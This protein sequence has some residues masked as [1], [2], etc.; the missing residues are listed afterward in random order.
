MN[1]ARVV[2]HV[3][4][5]DFL[6]RVR[7]YSFLVVL[8]ATVFACYQVHTGMIGIIVSGCRGTLNS[9]WIG[10]VMTLTATTLLGLVG[11]YIVNNSIALDEKSRVGQLLAATPVSKLQYISGKAL[12]NFCVLAVIVFVLMLSAPPLQLLAGEDKHVRLWVLIGPFI[13]VSLPVL[14]LIAALAIFSETVGWLRGAIGNVAYFLLFVGLLSSGFVAGLED[15][16]AIRYYETSIQNAAQHQLAK[17]QKPDFTFSIGMALAPRGFTW[18]GLDP[19]EKLILGRLKWVAVALGI[20]CLATLTFNRFEGGRLR[21]ALVKAAGP[22]REEALGADAETST[23]SDLRLPR[24]QPHGGLVP[25]STRRSGFPA[26]GLYRS[27]LTILLKGLGWWW[28]AGLLG[29][30]VAALLMPA[31]EFRQILWFAWIW[32]LRVWSHMGNRESRFNTGE[33]VFSSP[34]PLL[35]QLPATWLAGFS[36]AILAAS[37]VAVRMAVTGDW[38]GVEKVI[39]GAVFITS[40]ALGLGVTTGTSKLFE[41]A[42]TMLWYVG[43]LNRLAAVDY[44]QIAGSGD[45]SA[46]WLTASGCLLLAAFAG[47][48]MKLRR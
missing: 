37:G 48:A 43:P 5:A 6:E 23:Q 3:A 20:C 9:A 46:V 15:P 47:R 4:R 28:Y 30:I 26:L 18:D 44:M 42:Y 12:S 16:T 29:G 45:R 19:S 36:V 34:R 31:G 21:N 8:A 39:V 25:L 17:N 40:L 22:G 32:P 11:Y 10:A 35:R 13:L 14:A 1:A 33:V 38:L 41:A 27:E 7:R 2:Y 24:G